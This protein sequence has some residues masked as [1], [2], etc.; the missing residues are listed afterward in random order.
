MNNWNY[1]K[2]S[3][4]KICITKGCKSN[5]LKIQLRAFLIEKKQLVPATA[6]AKSETTVTTTAPA[7]A[8]ATAPAAAPFPFL[9]WA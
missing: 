6:P 7:T 3:N 9:G 5:K 8:T 1:L 4:D 2:F